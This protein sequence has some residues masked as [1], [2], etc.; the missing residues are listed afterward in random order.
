MATQKQANGRARATPHTAPPKIERY[1]EPGR[2]KAW[3]LRGG[4]KMHKLLRQPVDL[5]EE[6]EQEI[7]DYIAYHNAVG[8]DVAIFL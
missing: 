3:R 4:Q 7:C 2:E 6:D 5:G 8:V 1:I